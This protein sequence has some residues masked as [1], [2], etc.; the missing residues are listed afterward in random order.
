[1][2]ARKVLV[3]FHIIQSV[4]FVLCHLHHVPRLL[5]KCWS[6]SFTFLASRVV[7]PSVGW[8]DSLSL[9]Q[10]QDECEPVALL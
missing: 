6:F 5:F 10:G 8:L 1:M 2:R 9:F 7:F 3:H 4:H